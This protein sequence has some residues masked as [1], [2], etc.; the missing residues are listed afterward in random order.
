VAATRDLEEELL[1]T[2]VLVHG[3]WHGA[4]CW[5][6]I[7]PLLETEGHTVLTLDLPGH[8]DDDSPVSA[9]TLE[10][11]ARRVQ[12]ALESAAEPVV[13][14]GHS[15]GGMVVT[16]AAEYVP[17]RVRRLVYLTAFLPGDAQALPDLASSFEGADNVQPNLVVDEQSGTCVVA[18]GAAEWLFY[19]DCTPEATA[20]ALSRLRPEALAAFGSPVH[21]SEA[22]AGAIPRA[23]IECA[24]DQAITHAL[25]QHMHERLPCDPVL[26]IDTDHSPFLSRPRELAEHLLTLA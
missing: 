6:E 3:A 25:Q 1:T 10:S 5:R 12:E 4:W 23:Y 16:Q 13:L 7:T 15:M 14:V 17:D 21:V 2:F 11:Y 20:Y 9:M 22:G 19:G 18:D 24:R 26:S 8:G